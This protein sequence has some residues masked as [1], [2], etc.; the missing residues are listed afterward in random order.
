MTEQEWYKAEPGKGQNDI[1]K[2]L[3]TMQMVKCWNRLPR[4]VVDVP[5]LSIFK[6]RLDH[7]LNNIL[8]LLFSSEVV[9]QLEF[10]GLFQIVALCRTGRMEIIFLSWA[11]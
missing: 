3:F 8:L 1:R 9:R 5:C 11:T 10:L 7:A 4:E 6:R 2:K